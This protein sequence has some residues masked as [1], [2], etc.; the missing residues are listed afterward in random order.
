MTF[1]SYKNMILIKNNSKEKNIKE[2]NR[3][4]G[5]IIVKY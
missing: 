4:I 5:D 3:K 2:N 1:I